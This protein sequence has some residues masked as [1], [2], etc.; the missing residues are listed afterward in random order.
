MGRNL[1][2]IRWKG[3]SRNANE[4]KVPSDSERGIKTG[5][6]ENVDYVP[7]RHRETQFR[8]NVEERVVSLRGGGRLKDRNV[9]R[10]KRG[11]KNRSLRAG[12]PGQAG[13]AENKHRSQRTEE[14]VLLGKLGGD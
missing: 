14:R 7:E 1:S 4:Q 6:S 5:K 10:E 12:E 2:T 3:R 11:S 13:R 8:A 9:K